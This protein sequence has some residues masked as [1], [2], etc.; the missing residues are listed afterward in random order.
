LSR[1][2]NA[3]PKSR[4][5]YTV[6]EGQ[7]VRLFALKILLPPPFKDLRGQTPRSPHPGSL[8][9]VSRLLS[10]A[11]LATYPADLVLG[12]IPPV[13]GT[14]GGPRLMTGE[15]SGSSSSPRSRSPR[16]GTRGTSRF[17]TGRQ[18]TNRGRQFPRKSS[19][20]TRAV[21]TSADLYSTFVRTH[22]HGYIR[23]N[24]IK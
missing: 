3:P 18:S 15:R 23:H 8:S 17:S 22:A 9:L 13:H 12:N 11:R 1:G 20:A 24:T 14:Q 19:P 16:E 4:G 5:M 6:D 10:L 21:S 2:M 7:T